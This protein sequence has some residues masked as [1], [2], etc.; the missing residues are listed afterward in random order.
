MTER[1]YSQRVQRTLDVLPSAVLSAALEQLTYARGLDDE[2][3]TIAEVWR[4][5]EEGRDAAGVARWFRDS[6]WR[7]AHDMRL[8]GRAADTSDLVNLDPTSAS[9]A[10][11]E[12]Q[13]AALAAG[14]ANAAA[15]A[16]IGQ[17]PAL[18][19][20]LVARACHRGL[21]IVQTRMRGVCRAELGGQGVLPGVPAAV[22]VYRARAL[23]GVA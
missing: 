11:A 16:T 13:A 5:V 18:P 8:A 20:V 12:Y 3:I 2:L 7:E 17:E 4:L 10:A 21:R 19:V 14:W 23:G 6:R 22:D 9:L 15:F 1:T